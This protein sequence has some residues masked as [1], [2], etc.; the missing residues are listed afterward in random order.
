MAKK[1]VHAYF[2]GVVQGV[3]FRFTVRHLANH[4]KIK[5]WVKNLT[6]G[7]VELLVDGEQE[8]IDTFFKDLFQDMKRYIADYQL[9]DIQPVDDYDGFQIKF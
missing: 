3:G 6:D 5:G 4:H 9:E 7:R 1:C 8:S 2:K